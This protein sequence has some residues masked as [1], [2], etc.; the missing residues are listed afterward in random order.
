MTH[1][2]SIYDTAGLEQLRRAW[3]LDPHRIRELRNAL[4]KRFVAEPL[5]LADFPAADHLQLHALELYRQCDSTRDGATKLLLRTAAGHLIEAV[6][7]RIDT[8]R[9]TLC[10]SSQIG[11]AAACEFCAT[12]KMGIARNLTTAEILDQVLRAGQLLAAE[13]RRLRNIVFMGM[14]EPFHN[15]E[16][17]FQ[18]LALLI[19][20]DH[21][22]HAPT[23]TI[24]STV[25]VA[26]AMLR[27]A[28]RFPNVNLAL[29]LHSVRPE[30]RERLIPLAK[31]YPLDQLRETLVEL[32]RLQRSTVMIEY[33]LLAGVNDSTDDA[34]ELIAWLDGL[35]VHVNLIP[36]NAINE[37]PQL[38]GSDRT[39]RLA[40]AR[41]IRDAGFQTTLR[42][43]LGQDIAAACGQLVR[44]ENRLVPVNRL[45][46]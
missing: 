9:T 17:L 5:A 37:A 14:G 27:C 29:S 4:L 13:G 22:H 42:Y 19:S 23:K 3:R 25:G 11:C 34:R 45:S 32:N 41:Q 33:L 28:R 35:R 16:H 20:P 36:Y 24:V 21:F 15:E 39:A 2:I 30:I 18:A 44:Q 26:D 6:I 46:K 12:G 31:K 8:G 10:V 38:V 43:S 7:L 1:P 40:F